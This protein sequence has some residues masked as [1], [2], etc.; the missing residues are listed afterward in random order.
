M[1]LRALYLFILILGN[2]PWTRISD[3]SILRGRGSGY[4]SLS[5]RPGECS[6]REYL[7]SWFGPWT[8]SLV[9]P[10]GIVQILGRLL[11]LDG[12]RVLN[13]LCEQW[14]ILS[15]LADRLHVVCLGLRL[16]VDIVL[17]ELLIHLLLLVIHEGVELLDVELPPRE[18][19]VRVKL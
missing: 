2:D 9:S 18:I 10:L 4:I 11:L 19:H 5:L 16:L 1:L 3:F 14:K 6:W 12:F 15:H 8:E 17:G 7:L 13:L